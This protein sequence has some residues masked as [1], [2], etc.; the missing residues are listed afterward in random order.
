MV[1]MVLHEALQRLVDGVPRRR[2]VLRLLGPRDDTLEGDVMGIHHGR[3]RALHSDEILRLGRGQRPQ[4]RGSAPAGQ[5]K[6][7]QPATHAPQRGTSLSMATWAVLTSWKATVTFAIV[8]WAASTSS[9]RISIRMWRLGD[10]GETINGWGPS[11]DLGP[12]NGWSDRVKPH[13]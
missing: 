4:P 6:A 2:L 3:H 7:G 9:L 12:Y 13:R 11:S 5:E 8:F 1:S 10:G